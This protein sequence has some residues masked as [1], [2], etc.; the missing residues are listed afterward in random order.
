MIQRI[1]PA[2]G[3]ELYSAAAGQTW[4]CPMCGCEVPNEPQRPCQT[5]DGKKGKY[6]GLLRKEEEFGEI[7]KYWFPD[8]NRPALLRWAVKS[9]R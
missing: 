8:P 2:C 5:C 1:C 6:S 3:A 9:Q 7:E 4:V